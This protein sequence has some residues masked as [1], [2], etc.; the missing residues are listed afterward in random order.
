MISQV[1]AKNNRSLSELEIR[2]G[3]ILGFCGED[4]R[5][6]EYF[7]IMKASSGLSK[8]FSETR[9]INLEFKPK[10]RLNEKWNLGIFEKILG[11]R[12]AKLG[13]PFIV[14]VPRFEFE[15]S[16]NPH[17]SS[18]KVGTMYKGWPEIIGALKQNREGL[19]YYAD[20]FNRYKK[21]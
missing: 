6:A 2:S 7:Y 5:K 10:N 15:K 19:S 9:G 20:F 13:D 16:S 1:N 11:F 12:P 3:D 17:G 21:D 8:D 14:W 18:Y 4:I